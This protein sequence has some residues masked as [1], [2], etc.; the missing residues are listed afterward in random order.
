M[1]PIKRNMTENYSTPFYPNT[2][3]YRRTHRY[4]STDT[5]AL[6]VPPSNK[7]RRTP[8]RTPYSPPHTHTADSE[9]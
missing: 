1:T 5:A 4:S 7:C 8:Y 6:P 3:R 9:F 2:P